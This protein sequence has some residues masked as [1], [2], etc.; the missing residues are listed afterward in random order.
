M[1]KLQRYDVVVNAFG[2]TSMKES[3]DG[4][5]LS[6]DQVEAMLEELYDDIIRKPELRDIIDAL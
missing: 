4:N 5:F 6:A 2:G 3:E 1:S